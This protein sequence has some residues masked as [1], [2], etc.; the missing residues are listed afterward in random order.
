MLLD[1]NVVLALMWRQAYGHDAAHAWLHRPRRFYTTPATEWAALRVS[2]HKARGT[3]PETLAALGSVIH[4]QKQQPASDA[5]LADLDWPLWQHLHGYKL[6]SDFWLVATAE[7]LGTELITLD[8]R[9]WEILPSSLRNRV[10]V[11]RTQ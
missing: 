8:A 7:A 4:H 9:A 1:T 3:V 6:V 10:L 2:I 5:R 11:L